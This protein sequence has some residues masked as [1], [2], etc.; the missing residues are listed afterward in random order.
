MSSPLPKEFIPE[1]ISCT[2]VPSAAAQGASPVGI[3]NIDGSGH[4]IN[5]TINTNSVSQGTN[6]SGGQ[7]LLPTE[8]QKRDSLWRRLKK[9]AFVVGTWEVLKQNAQEGWAWLLKRWRGSVVVA[10]LTVVTIGATTI[11]ITTA[12]ELDRRQPRR[13]PYDAG[14]EH[15]G[16]LSIS[17]KLALDSLPHDLSHLQVP[18]LP[19]CPYQEEVRNGVMFVKVCGGTFLMGSDDDPEAHDFEKPAHWVN[20]SDFWIG[21]Y[22]VSNEQYEAYKAGHRSTFNDPNLPV[23]DVTWNEARAYCRSLGGDLPTEAEWEYAARGTDGRR[24][25]WGNNPEPNV[26]HA[27]FDQSYPYFGPEVITTKPNGRGPFGTQNQ[28]GNV[29]EWVTDCW[30]LAAYAQRNTRIATTTSS[31]TVVNPVDDRPGCD[32]HVLRGGSFD[33]GAWFLRSASRLRFE[34]SDWLNLL[35]FRCVLSSRRQS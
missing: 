31:S 30:D 34:H 5:V 4:T 18:L 6:F 22:E 26:E 33:Y 23:H 9:A 14:I 28:A 13:N 32:A 10:G 27:V 2:D 29:W 11:M 35:G 1:S 3:K 8:G 17:Q 12:N 16:D 21:K 25:P 24:Y 19:T 15:H 7:N 20:L